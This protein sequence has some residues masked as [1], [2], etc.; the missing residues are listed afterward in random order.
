M[1]I[2]N[3]CKQE[4]SLESFGK[5]KSS[6][7]KLAYWCKTCTNQNRQK[8]YRQ[9]IANGLCLRGCGRK[10]FN[11]NQC[12]PCKLYAKNQLRKNRQNAINYYGCKCTC[13]GETQ[14]EFLTFEHKNGDGAEHRRKIKMIGSGSHFV[15]WLKQNN[16]PDSIEI[17]CY[18]CN[19]SKGFRGYCP[20]KQKNG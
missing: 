19:C 5:R 15:R 16:Y 12:E 18:N 7:D 1:K 11:G 17:L 14:E 8:N 10:L 9:H 2:C 20:H 13:C 6:R 4:K 3:R